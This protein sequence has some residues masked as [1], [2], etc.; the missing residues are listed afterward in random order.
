VVYFSEDF[1]PHDHRFLQALSLAGQE[2]H[3]VR[4]HESHEARQDEGVPPG[5]RLPE[6]WAGRGRIE[7]WRFPG[8]ARQLRRALGELRPD[9]V[10]AGPVQRPALLAALAQAHPLLTM[11]WGS[12]LLWQARSGPGR[13]AA[14]YVLARSDVLACDCQAVRQR[15]QRL[16]MADERIVVFPW[17]VDLE[18]FSPGPSRLRAEL[19]WDQA[20]VVLSARSWE[21][22]LGV[23]LLVEGFIRAAAAG[24]QLRLLMLGSGSMEASVR[25]R[26]RETHLEERVHF[27]GPVTFER[28]PDYYRCA[29]LYVSASRSDGSSISLLEAM[30]CGLPALVSDI[31][32]NRE[33]V[34]PEENGRWFADGAIDPLADELQ[35]FHDRPEAWEGLGR[36]S[37]EIAEQRADWSRNFPRLLEG[38]ELAR[39]HAGRRQ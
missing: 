18:H 15:A 36:R 20:V 3:F 34:E 37:R 19:G 9:V 33:W 17:G 16:G 23:D 32:G 38:Y 35:S 5:V 6:V 8:A 13:W 25:R 7:W 28:L 21:P 4:L 22:L 27:A 31:P 24:P 12:D 26:I 30:A 29:D 10:H 1:G 11:S 14:R 2:V 39:R